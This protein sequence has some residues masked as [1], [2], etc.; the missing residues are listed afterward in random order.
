MVRRGR[1]VGRGEGA[2]ALYSG[3]ENPLRYER[4]LQQLRGW[5]PLHWNCTEFHTSL[6][7]NFKLAFF[8]FDVQRCSIDFSAGETERR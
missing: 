8:P 7:C 2:A 1:V 3:K 4:G 6:R 5:P